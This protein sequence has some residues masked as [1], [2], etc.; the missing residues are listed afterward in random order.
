MTTARQ[1]QTPYLDALCAYAER[2]PARLHVPGHKGGAGADPGMLA[3]F[4]ERA[5]SMD[6]PALT[7]G[8]DVGVDPTPFEQAQRLAAEAWGA[9][10]AWFLINGASQGNLA[11][12][13]ALAHYGGEVVIQRNAHSSAIDALVLSG[14][15]P[16]FAAPEVDPE[17]GIAHCLT[18]ATLEQA[19][20]ATPGAVAAWAISPTY[21][22]AVADVAALASVSHARG[23]PLVVDEAWGAHMAFHEQLP[24]HALAL[25]ADLV[26]SS[27]HKIVGSLTQS[28]MLHLGHGDGLIGE[29][30]VDRAVTLT[31]S[32]SPNSLLCGSLDAAR[33]Q[34]AVHGR[35]LLGRTMAALTQARE[36]ISAIEGLD[37]LDDRL[38]GRR[39][40]FA[41]D[42]LRLA[43]DVRGVNASGYELAPMLREIDDINMELYGQNVLVAVFG[44]GERGLPEAA[45]L[46]AAL[47]T[48]VERVGLNP[49][50]SRE[51]FAAPPPWGELAMTPREAYLGAQE[52]VPAAQ[53]AGRIAAESLATYPPGIPNVLPGERLTA[54]TL[55]YVQNT[56]ELGGSV[57]GASDRLLRTVRVVVEDGRG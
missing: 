7:H 36:E 48:A 6:I 22:G 46:V 50:G 23:V 10:R 5:V 32:T 39:G 45:R 1:Q 57:R 20:E 33:R 19:L 2:N 21:F 8:I 54:E 25:G 27:T 24:E 11:A 16:T 35:E 52:V 43:V 34:A 55:A 40:V 26:I 9:K 37:V 17:L 38:A 31:E 41:Y 3:A 18:P 44:M 56:L 47:R 14:L 49:G 30:T 13:L 4:G 42:P 29:D 28:A 15:R 51:S 12:G 53:A